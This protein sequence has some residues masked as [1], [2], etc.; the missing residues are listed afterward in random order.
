MR[1]CSR[2]LELTQLTYDSSHEDNLLHHRGAVSPLLL[3]AWGFEAAPAHPRDPKN[4]S[5]LAGAGKNNLPA[6]AALPG[7]RLPSLASLVANGC[8]LT[9]VP[10]RYPIF[11]FFFLVEQNTPHLDRTDAKSYFLPNSM[12]LRFILNYEILFTSSTLALN[13]ILLA[14]GVRRRS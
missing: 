7:G 14:L 13:T 11:F 4:D 1:V 6:A 9:F 8:F 5:L 10:Y 2:G 3:P 12:Q